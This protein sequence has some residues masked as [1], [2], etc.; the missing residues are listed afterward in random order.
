MKKE[1]FT[2]LEI[3]V[4]MLILSI[5]VAGS[6]G[7]MVT[8][9]KLLVNA[10]HRLQ[11][12]N[13]AQAVLERLRMYVSADPNNPAGSG[14]AFDIKPDHNP[15]DEIGLSPGPDIPGVNSPAW[16]YNVAQVLG[17]RCRQVEVTT[18]WEEL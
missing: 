1:G 5:V 4:S 6:F 17:S 2:L 8:T 16:S 3:I 14:G 11:A 18:T 9:N 15:S 12:V 7:M 10:E 13:Q